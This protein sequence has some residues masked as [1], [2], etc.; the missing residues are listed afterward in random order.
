MTMAEHDRDGPA[1][2]DRLESFFAAA[3]DAA[4]VPGAGLLVRVLAGAEAVQGAGVAPQGQR[5]GARPMW[6]QGWAAAIAGA[7]ASV[8]GDAPGGWR[9][10]GGMAAAALA[11]VWIGYAGLADGAT[12]AL[13]IAAGPVAGRA[14]LAADGGADALMPEDDDFEV[15]ALAL[16]P[17]G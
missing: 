4:P 12:G 3:R 9:S 14:A 5:R 1:G 2:D 6:G 8:I 11:G 16:G 17:E 13:G 10:L 15:F 7:V